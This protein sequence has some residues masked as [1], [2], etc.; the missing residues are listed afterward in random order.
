MN[1]YYSIGSSIFLSDRYENVFQSL[2][3]IGWRIICLIINTQ[4][5]KQE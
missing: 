4:E 2:E 5:V 1:K 3:R